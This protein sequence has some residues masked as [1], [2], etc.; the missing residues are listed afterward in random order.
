MTIFQMFSGARG[1]LASVQTLATLRKTM[2]R[3]PPL[4]AMDGC[5]WINTPASWPAG[6]LSGGLPGTAPRRAPLAGSASC[7]RRRLAI[8]LP[9]VLHG[10]TSHGSH[11]HLNLVSGSALRETQTKTGILSGSERRA[12]RRKNAL[13]EMRLWNP[14]VHQTHRWET[15]RQEDEAG[16]LSASCG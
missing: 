4:P 9:T 7:P 6:R 5:W 10:L 15:R 16:V 1:C 11:L 2:S 8:L 14:V 3:E 12:C 13:E